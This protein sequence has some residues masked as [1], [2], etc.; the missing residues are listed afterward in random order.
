M[1]IDWN[2]HWVTRHAA[3]FSSVSSVCPC[4]GSLLSTLLFLL[5]MNFFILRFLFHWSVFSSSFS[6]V[7]AERL[8]SLKTTF[9][10]RFKFVKF[11]VK[12]ESSGTKAE[13]RTDVY[14]GSGLFFMNKYWL[15]YVL[16]T[17]RSVRLIFFCS[18]RLKFRIIFLR[19]NCF[20]L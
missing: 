12:N 11:H 14:R 20:W 4:L 5:H 18:E 8:L 1:V 17:E 9:Q 13:Q 10:L 16:K 2:F 6:Q 3:K 7:A 15:F 19:K